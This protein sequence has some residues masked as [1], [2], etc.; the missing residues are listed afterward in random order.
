ML[1]RDGSGEEEE[2]KILIAESLEDRR[3]FAI[4]KVERGVYVLCGLAQW[5]SL[6]DIS[7][8][9]IKK[10]RFNACKST[11]DPKRGAWWAAASIDKLRPQSVECFP[12]RRSL[13]GLS[14]KPRPNVTAERI[15]P[16]IIPQEVRTSGVDVTK[17]HSE[18]H[19]EQTIN[20]QPHAIGDV[21]KQYLDALY[22]SKAPLA[23]FV[24]GPLSRARV[25]H[26]S[27]GLAMSERPNLLEILR[28]SILPV[29]GKG[30]SAK[31]D[32]KY[33]TSIPE[34]VKEIPPGST[35]DD[36]GQLKSIFGD[37]SR[38]SRKR[39]KINPDGFF[40]GEEDYI[41]KWWIDRENT[42]T[43]GS[44]DDTQEKRIRTACSCQK[45]REM[46]LQVV[47]ILE[48]LAL[49]L[50]ELNEGSKSLA[51]ATQP[52]DL[53]SQG[54]IREDKKSTDYSKILDILL[55]KLQI[56]ETTNQEILD[57]GKGDT[58]AAS[59]IKNKSSRMNVGSD[60]LRSF[61]TEVIMPL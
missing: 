17:Q 60:C 49:E 36:E 22:V 31:I 11:I 47:L 61:C 55:E 41:V 8:K 46:Q 3:L 42:T 6:G 43:N 15:A 39:K 28:S 18:L 34:L 16:T 40:P 1:E 9:A 24:K 12:I 14:M 7:R 52:A 13:L 50:Q 19:I 30:N 57:L 5:V 58:S 48:I 59:T 20:T 54:I 26:Q 56:W 37:K 45:P 21:R 35:A 4:E 2:V 33:A 51:E 25:E 32:K 27:T 53:T 10:A 29:K 38:K 23:Y 44:A